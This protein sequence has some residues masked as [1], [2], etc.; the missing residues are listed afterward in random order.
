MTNKCLTGSPKHQCNLCPKKFKTK[1]EQK[2]HEKR[3]EK[4]ETVDCPTCFRSFNKKNIR[5][6]ISMSKKCR[7]AQIETDKCV[8]QDKK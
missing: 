6:H 2:R 3:H 7:N 1:D 5:K 4:D 8:F